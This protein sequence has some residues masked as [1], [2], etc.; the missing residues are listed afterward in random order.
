MIAKNT[1]KN[2]EDELDRSVIEKPNNI[3]IKYLD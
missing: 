1:R 2:L 3:E